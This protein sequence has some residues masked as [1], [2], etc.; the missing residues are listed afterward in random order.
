MKGVIE[1]LSN[2]RAVMRSLSRWPF[3]TVFMPEF[4]EAVRKSPFELMRIDNDRRNCHLWARGVYERWMRNRER[5]EADH[6]ERLWRTFLLLNTGVAVT[7][8]RRSHSATA[9][10]VVLELPADTDGA[11]HTTM[12]VGAIDRARGLLRVVRDSLFGLW[13]RGTAAAPDPGMNGP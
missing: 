11:F 4:I 8:D 13:P 12:T 10:R 1:D 9:Y 2:Y 3:R 6:G 5:I 7:M